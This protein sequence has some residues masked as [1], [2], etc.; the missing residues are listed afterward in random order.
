MSVYGSGRGKEKRGEEAQSTENGD[1]S[2]TT[3]NQRDC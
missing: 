2:R 3:H 1:E